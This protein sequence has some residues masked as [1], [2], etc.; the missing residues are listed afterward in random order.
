MKLSDLSIRRPVLASMV[1]LALVLFGAIGY[2]RLAVRDFPTWTRR[3]SPSAPCCRAPTPGRRVGRHRHPR[4]GAEHR[5]GAAHPDQLER[6]RRQQHHPRVQPRPEVEA[7][8]Q[9]PRD[10]VARVRGRLPED[11]REPVVAKQDADAQPFFWLAL[12]GENYDL[13]SSP[14]SATAWSRAGCRPCPAWTRPASSASA[15]S[16]CGSGSRPPSSRPAA[17]RCRTCSRPSDPERRVP[18]GRI[19]SDRREFTVRSLGELKTPQEF[20]ELDH[21]PGAGQARRT[22]AAS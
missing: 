18:A 16:R 4:G 20:A 11:V 6:R 17:S 13:L 14:T 3:S 2:T 12:S 8:A 10:K 15:A 5:R 22:P 1:S 19:E 9:D 21:T 7:A